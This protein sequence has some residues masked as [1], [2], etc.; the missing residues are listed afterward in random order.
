VY[1]R[2]AHAPRRCANSREQREPAGA[3]IIVIRPPTG[4]PPGSRTGLDS[5][6]VDAAARRY[7]HGSFP[8]AYRR[9]D[10]QACVRL[11]AWCRQPKIH[12]G[13]AN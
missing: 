12:C 8:R 5:A 1:L 9:D 7:A 13:A 2:C 6:S 11:L 4:K 10:V 3:E